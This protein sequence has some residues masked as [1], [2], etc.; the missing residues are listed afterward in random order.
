MGKQYVPVLLYVDALGKVVPKK[1]KAGYDGEWVKIDKVTDSRRMASLRAGGVGIRY[2]C[3]VSYD[4]MTRTIYLFDEQGKWF[5][6][7]DE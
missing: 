7:T 5:V 6:A 3:I 2:S 4:D 1:M